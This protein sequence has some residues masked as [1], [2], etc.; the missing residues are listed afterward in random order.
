M[1]HSLEPNSSIL[2]ST[3]L[4]NLHA[5]SQGEIPRA[6]PQVARECLGYAVSKT[7]SPGV[8]HSGGGGAVGGHH[9]KLEE[10][11]LGHRR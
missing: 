7:R 11:S 2:Y 10:D 3:R 1:S 5:A 9:S 6:S 4:W 8:G